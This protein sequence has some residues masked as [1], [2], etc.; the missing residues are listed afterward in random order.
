M[1]PWHVVSAATAKPRDSALSPL[2]SPAVYLVCGDDDF[3]VKETAREIVETLVPD[4][5]RD[6]GLETIDGDCTTAD[7]ACAAMR[8]CLE[9]L[10]TPGFFGGVKLTWLK[11]VSFFASPKKKGGDSEETRTM[12]DELVARIRSGSVTPDLPLL[13]ST[14]SISRAS[15]LFKAVSAAGKV[16]DFGSGKKGYELERIAE[17]RLND[18]LKRLKFRMEGPARAAFLDRVGADMRRM[19]SELEKLRCYAGDSGMA[20]VADVEA[21][22]SG[23]R[24]TANWDLQDAFG[25]RDAERLTRVFRAVLAQG[26]KAIGLSAMLD[27]RVRDLLLARDALDRG[28]VVREGR[29]IRWNALPQEIEEWFENDPKSDVRAGSAWRFSRIVD[30]ASRWRM[31]ELRLARY[32]LVELREQMVS[33]SLSPEFLLESTMLR[34]IGKGKRSPRSA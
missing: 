18:Q 5:L 10:S 19:S 26:E 12:V 7:A 23:G 6:M 1:I 2:D 14:T 11:D 3:L 33:S 24:E 28:W 4:D 34:C 16:E 20:T 25:E 15:A 13:V 32:R 21:V 9:S 31:N 22:V 29:S 17:A 30:Q 8:R 27:S